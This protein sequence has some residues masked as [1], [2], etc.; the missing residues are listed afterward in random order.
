[1][2]YHLELDKIGVLPLWCL[3]SPLIMFTLYNI[4]NIEDEE[5]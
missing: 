3:L 5:S 1:M 2:I 4:A